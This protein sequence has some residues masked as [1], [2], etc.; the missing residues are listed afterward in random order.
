MEMEPMQYS[1]KFYQLILTLAFTMLAGPL[2]VES[3]CVADHSCCIPAEQITCCA[4]DNHPPAVPLD[5]C[6]CA[7]HGS[8]PTSAATNSNPTRLA[9]KSVDLPISSVPAIGMIRLSES[10][11]IT[12]CSRQLDQPAI[13]LFR[14]TLRWRC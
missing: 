13:S 6:R 11:F 9:R 10:G 14:L 2:L 4:K 7:G 5:H 1:R 12:S 8:Q 3:A